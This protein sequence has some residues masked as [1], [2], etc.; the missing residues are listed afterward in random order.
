MKC[1]LVAMQRDCGVDDADMDGTMMM[2]TMMTMTM[3]VVVLVQLRQRQRCIHCSGSLHS[4][5]PSKAR[6]RSVE[7]I[8]GESWLAMPRGV[9]RGRD[10]G[11]LVP[12]YD[13]I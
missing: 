7:H 3:M 8:C 1:D 2:M 11:A 5:R 6:C 9:K 4:W 13:F 12:W 10:T